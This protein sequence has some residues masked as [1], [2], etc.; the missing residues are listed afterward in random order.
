MRHLFNPVITN[1]FP[2]R[3]SGFP[4]GISFVPCSGGSRFPPSQ[5]GLGLWMTR[6]LPSAETAAIHQLQS[7]ALRRVFWDAS[8]LS[9]IFAFFG[10]G[11]CIT[12]Q[13]MQCTPRQQQWV[14]CVADTVL[15]LPAIQNCL[16]AYHHTDNLFKPQRREKHS[17]FARNGGRMGEPESRRF[18][19]GCVS[20][21]NAFYVQCTET[22][23]SSTPS[24]ERTIKSVILHH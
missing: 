18:V 4:T 16:L 10:L 1:T 3:Q 8:F 2:D 17:S 11:L 9:C 14:V 15:S 23:A 20:E 6:F 5:E 12:H 13:S 24:Q 21:E 19:E 22:V 7:C